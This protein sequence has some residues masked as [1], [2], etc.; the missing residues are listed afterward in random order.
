[1]SSRACLSL[2][3][4]AA[5]LC[6]PAAGWAQSADSSHVVSADSATADVPSSRC[7][8]IHLREAAHLNRQRMPRYSALS[9]GRSRGISRRLI[10]TERL[11]IPVAWYVD[12][13][14]RNFLRAGIRVTCDDIVP[15]AHTPAFRERVADPPPLSSFTPSDPRRMRRT[16][17]GAY[18]SGGFP[19]ASA[20]IEHE[21][22]HLQN[23]PAFHC[24]MRHLLESALRISNQAPVYEAQAR[25]RGLRSPAGVSRLMLNLHLSTLGEAAKLDR[26]AAPL[27]AEGIPI[28]CQDVPPIPPR[29]DSSAPHP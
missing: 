12:W 20:A 17:D 1:M 18:R 26:R 4:L 23:T 3:L 25:E 2:A 15:M 6:V 27:Q 9:G 19:A 16:I 13:R 28:I 22:Q 14:A 29:A 24:M 7:M 21:I 10:W 5:A 8:E 11:G